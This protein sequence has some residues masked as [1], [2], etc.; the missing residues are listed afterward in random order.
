MCRD[1]VCLALVAPDDGVFPGGYLEVTQRSF[2]SKCGDGPATD[3]DLNWNVSEIGAARTLNHPEPQVEILGL[4]LQR[5]QMRGADPS[6]QVGDA[7][8]RLGRRRSGLCASPESR[9]AGQGDKGDAH[10]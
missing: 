9:G 8:L 1:G 10:V 7:R 5:V 2:R 4:C 3:L 6:A